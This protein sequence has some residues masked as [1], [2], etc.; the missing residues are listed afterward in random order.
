MDYLAKITHQTLVMTRNP[1]V[2][3]V[4]PAILEPEESRVD[5]RYYLELFVQKSFKSSQYQ[6]LSLQEA[7]EK[8]I[9]QGYTSSPGAYFEIQ[10]RLDDQLRPT[11]PIYGDRSV[12]ICPDLIR[13]YYYKTERW[14]GDQLLDSDTTT[15]LWAIRAQ[16]AMRHYSNYKDSFFT[17]VIGPSGKFLTWQPDG[18]M[19]G[20]DQ[21]ERLY[22]LTNFTP[23]PTRLFLRVNVL[24]A[25]NSRE[26]F[27]AMQAD[28]VSHM[29]V[30]CFPVGFSELGLDQKEK[31]VLSYQVWISNENMNQV[32]ESRSFRVDHSYYESVRYLLFQNSL[33]GY[34]TLRCVGSPTES[35]S[36]QRQVVERFVDYDYLPTVSE[37]LINN[38]T[39]QRQITLNVG[40]WLNTDYREY[41]EELLLSEDFY[42]QDGE[43]F[44]PLSPVFTQLLTQSV[45]EWPI[46]RSLTFNFSNLIGGYSRLPKSAP[47]AR[48]TGWR[49][50]SESC[51]LDG[52]GIRTG[53][54]M[55]NE[56]VKYYL[57]TGDNVRP[58]VTKSNVAGTE[59]YI[60]P[61]PSEDCDSD[62]TPFR[63]TVQTRQ[64]TLKRSNC[65]T[66]RIGLTWLM[67]IPA[68]S[69]GSE[70]SQADADSK[71]LNALS[72]LDKQS[73][74]DIQGTCV[75]PTPLRIGLVNDC[76]DIGDGQALPVPSVNMGSKMIISNHTTVGQVRF[77]DD[78]FPEGVYSLDVPVIFSFA[79]TTAFKILIPSKNVSSPALNGN[80]TYRFANI[81]MNYGD[82]DLIIYVER[83]QWIN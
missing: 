7:S 59:G 19:V 67:T 37:V 70:L 64:S 2:V 33:G 79:P 61:W 76:P 3:I 29:S 52:N 65:G 78:T 69:Y 47:V 18:K 51:E 30:Y 77:S 71:A 40:N 60:S 75:L 43:E 20:P 9:P 38:V 83:A 5:L 24:Y 55:V 41:F 46:E 36:V 63:S 42:I 31:M 48:E 53:R 26:T 49:Q 28:N 1:I 12:S 62:K 17:D 72:G 22:F 21:P 82:P 80:Q 11:V 66:G 10:T 56:I 32:S 8:P 35:V 23:S 45:A 6:A 54:K 74:A 68:G 15:T 27:T 25:D 50:Y 13:Q 4:D 57:D 34:D 44:I 16:L 39:G 81:R 73:N 58:L 14:N